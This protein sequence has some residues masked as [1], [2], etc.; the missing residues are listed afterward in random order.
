MAFK[1]F[2][3]FNLFLLF[4]CI[5]VHATNSFLYSQ[6]FVEPSPLKFRGV[7]LKDLHESLWKCERFVKKN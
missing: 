4:C 7:E 3:C 1:F 2:V 5:N 6:D